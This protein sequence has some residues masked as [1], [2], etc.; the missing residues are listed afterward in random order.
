MIRLNVS[1]GADRLAEA[2]H[3]APETMDIAAERGL[4]AAAQEVTRTAKQ[5]APK[6]STLL[7]NSIQWRRPGRF[8]RVIAPGTPYADD[9]DQGTGV[10]GPKG[11][12]SGKLP[13]VQSILDWIRIRRIAP[14][15]QG[16]SDKALAYLIAHGIART[17]TRKNPFMERAAEKSA[18]PARKRLLASVQLG[19]AEVLA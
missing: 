16:M 14:R 1:Y 11:S 13:P 7:T 5:E 17:G 15:T 9:V 19:I 4:D 2:M 3:K 6:S 8:I 18:E 10:F 12:A